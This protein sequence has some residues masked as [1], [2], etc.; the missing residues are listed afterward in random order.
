MGSGVHWI[1]NSI[2]V[3]AHWI[4]NFIGVMLKMKKNQISISIKNQRIF[5]MSLQFIFLLIIKKC[6][7]GSKQKRFNTKKND[8]FFLEFWGFLFNI[9]H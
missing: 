3:G 2:G 8:F 4:G 6:R 9:S 5:Y 1:G 7:N